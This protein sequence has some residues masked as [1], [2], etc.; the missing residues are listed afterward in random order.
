MVLLKAFLSCITLAV[1]TF[2]KPSGYT[3]PKHVVDYYSPAHYSFKYGV[4][5]PATGDVKQQHETREGDVVKGQYSLVEPDGSV[6]TVD[7]TADPVNG[8][9]A[10]V[11]KSPGVHPPAVVAAKPEPVA[12][13]Y[14]VAAPALAPA[15]AP[16]HLPDIPVP[17]VPYGPLV[18]EPHPLAYGE[19][20]YLD[21][22][23]GYPPN[24]LDSY[25]PGL[26]G[27]VASPY[28]HYGLP[29]HDIY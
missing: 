24:T 25:G 22:G 27:H 8:F 18:E 23:V 17:A 6:R 5:D 9:N 19:I 4:H 29:F 16:A 11:S 3:A 10:V 13:V 12:P 28:N 26:Y 20:S 7:Y 21:T 14:T 1:P 2:S 15:L